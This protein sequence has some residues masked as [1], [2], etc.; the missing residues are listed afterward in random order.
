V[1]ELVGVYNHFGE[2]IKQ[3][4]INKNITLREMARR[5]YISAPFLSDIEKGRRLPLDMARMDKMAAV[6]E[7]DEE[8]RSFM[9]DLAGKSRDTVAPD[10]PDYIKEREYVTAAL[11]TARDLGVGEKEWLQFVEELKRRKGLNV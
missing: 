8:E 1:I 10:L 2:F 7:L 3:K 6:L 4:R 5:I 9:F 11:R